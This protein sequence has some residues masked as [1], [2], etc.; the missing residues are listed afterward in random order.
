MNCPNCGKVIDCHQCV[1]PWT[2][3][4][5][6]KAGDV[7][8]CIGCRCVLEFDS[9]ENLRTVS[10]EKMGEFSPELQIVLKR[11]IEKIGQVKAMQ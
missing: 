6:P 8:I 9:T 4:I 5:K 2:E 1:T 3:D 7:T 11:T 10:V